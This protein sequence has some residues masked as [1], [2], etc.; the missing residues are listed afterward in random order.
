MT[1]IAVFVA[2]S[3]VLRGHVGNAPDALHQ[4]REPAHFRVSFLLICCSASQSGDLTGDVK[5][6]DSGHTLV[7]VTFPPY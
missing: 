6:T 2:D 5:S 4:L 3:E 1:A 7:S